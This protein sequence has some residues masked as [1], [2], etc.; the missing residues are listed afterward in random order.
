[1]NNCSG[2][3]YLRS[4]THFDGSTMV[5]E[6]VKMGGCGDG[7]LNCNARKVELFL[8]QVWIFAGSEKCGFV[9]YLP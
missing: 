7:L 8:S 1:M 9:P 6:N 2:V 3:N 4:F 5:V